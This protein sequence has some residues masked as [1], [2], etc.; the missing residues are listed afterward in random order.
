MKVVFARSFLFVLCLVAIFLGLVV[1]HHGAVEEVV[2]KALADHSLDFFIGFAT[3]A[4]GVGL[5]WWFR[6]SWRK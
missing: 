3:G 5:L 4:F 2:G 6:E 1:G